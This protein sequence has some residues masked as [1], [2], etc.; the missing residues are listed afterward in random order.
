[1]NALPSS[2]F[3]PLVQGYWRMAHW[4]MTPQQRLTFIKQHVELG[5]TS[6]DHAPVYQSEALF[7]EALALE[8]SLR[9][10]LQVISKCGIIPGQG[11]QVAHYDSGQAE[12]IT[13]VERSLTN[14]QVEKLDVLLIHRPDLL[15]QVDEMAEAFAQL[16]A[17]GKV[18]HFGVSNFSVAEFNLLQSRLDVPLVTN[19]IEI[20]PINMQA[21]EDGT[22][23][24]MQQLKVRPMAWSCLAGGQLFNGESAQAKRVQHTL[25]QVADEIGAS[26]I[27]EVAY[28]WVMK[29]PANPVPIIGSGKIA[30]VQTA[31]NALELTMTRE[32]WYRI[33]AATKGHG[34][35]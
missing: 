25:Q 10:Q 35:A 2:L 28:A 18:E 14:L 27:D 7:G 22:L 30:R 33:W 5:V 31:L 17:A 6:V 1:M 32:Q 29:L 4:N 34:V 11:E 13:S 15:M 21:T 19:Q 20:N 24:Q 26:C 8:P 3:S 9:A 23:A 12:I 16:K